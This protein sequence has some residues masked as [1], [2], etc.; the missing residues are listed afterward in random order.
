MAAIARQPRTLPDRT[1]R[2]ALLWLSTTIVVV[3]AAI[4]LGAELD[5]PGCLL[6]QGLDGHPGAGGAR[7]SPRRYPRGGHERHGRGAYP[8]ARCAVMAGPRRARA[9]RPAL[10]DSR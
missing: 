8:L 2:K 1:H 9:A 7:A 6:R 5:G 10:S 4:V 3:A